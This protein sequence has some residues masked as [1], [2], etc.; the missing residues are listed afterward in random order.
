MELRK[1]QAKN[2]GANLE[3]LCINGNY[4]NYTLNNFIASVFT[5]E[6]CNNMS[7][8]PYHPVKEV[9]SIMKTPELVK[10]KLEALNLKGTINGIIIC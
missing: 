1:I 9:Y 4:R 10:K 7:S 5:I 2:K 8:T 6:D 3:A